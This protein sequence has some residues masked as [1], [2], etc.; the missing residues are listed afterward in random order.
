[1]KIGI[2]Q[3]VDLVKEY[4]ERRDSLDQN[5]TRFINEFGLFLVPLSNTIDR[6]EEYVHSLTLEGIILSGGNATRERNIFEKKL[7]TYAIE[8]RI[9]VIGVCKGMQFIN[10]YFGG[11][12]DKVEGHV[13]VRHDVEI[14]AN[15]DGF[16]RGKIEV[17]SFHEFGVHKDNVAKNMEI[18]GICNDNTI[19]AFAHKTL[20]IIGIMWHPEREKDFKD[21]DIK[22]FRDFFKI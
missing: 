12:I 1:M 13:K 3:R 9:P 2:T 19:E 15:R 8:K 11:K 16:I 17:N 18:I 10:E 7:L 21:V 5:W 20:P 14:I 6:V 22:I 4:R